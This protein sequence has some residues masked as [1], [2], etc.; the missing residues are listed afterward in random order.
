MDQEWEG[1]RETLECQ[2]VGGGSQ[3]AKRR[4][5]E[6]EVIWEMGIKG[7]SKTERQGDRVRV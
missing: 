6:I 1:S 4:E 7:D 3:A 5:G 2:G